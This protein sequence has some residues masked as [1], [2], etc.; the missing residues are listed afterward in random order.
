MS[1]PPPFFPQPAPDSRQAV[2]AMEY[3][4]DQLARAGNTTVRNVRA[5]QDR[6]LIDPPER[7]GRV[8]IY[9]QAHLG[10]LAL[11]NHLLSRG[12]TLANVQELLAALIDGQELHAILGLEKA[13]N[14]PWAVEQPRH[15]SYLELARMFGTAI[16][17]SGLKR[18][19]ALGLLEREGMGFTC[20]TP[21]MLEAG[22]A[23][24]KAGFPLESVLDLMEG[25]R[26][27]LQQVSDQVVGLVVRRLDKYGDANLPPPE[28][29]PQLVDTIWDIRPLAMVMVETEM[30]RALELSANKFLGDRVASIIERLNQQPAPYPVVVA[31]PQPADDAA[32]AAAPEPEP[33]G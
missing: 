19:L 17:L 22:E 16:S 2:E 10:R 27:L 23:L 13:I 14:S 5:Y 11:I 12:Y 8:G 3:T 33:R 24:T 26:P 9:T 21:R 20:R 4:I 32:A 18:A 31:P 30:R 15:Y 1:S 28:D 29:V 25:A 7:R 6:G